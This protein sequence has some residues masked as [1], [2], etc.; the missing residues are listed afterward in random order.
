[1]NRDSAP[2]DLSEQEYS[3]ALNANF[4]SEHGTGQVNLQNEPSNIYCSGFKE[5]YKVIGHKYHLNQDRT[6]FFLTN[7]T[8]GFSEIGYINS[9]Y[10][11]DGLEQVEKECGC[12]I[13]VI[14][15]TP[16]EDQVQ[17]AT[18]TYNTLISDECELPS[19]TKCLNFSIDHPI[20]ES[21]IQIKDEASGTNMYFTDNYNPQRYLQLDYLDQYYLD[22]TACGDP[23]TVCLQ[24]DKLRVYP[25][26]EPFCITVDTIE[27]GGSL[28]AGNIEVIGAYSSSSGTELSE[29]FSLTNRVPIYDENNNI[30]DQTNLNYRTNQAVRVSVSG[31]DDKFQYYKLVVIYRSGLDGAVNYF[32]YG[33]YPTTTT[34]V[35][36]TDLTDLNKLSLQ[37]INTVKPIY[38]KA[39]G[40][41]Q[42]NGYLFQFGLTAKREINLQKVVSLM[43]AH[44]KWQTVKADEDLYKRGDAVSNYIGYMRDEVEP[45]SIRFLSDG[46]Y[47]SPNFF[48]IPRP[49]KVFELDVLG[50]D[51]EETVNETSILEFSPDCSANNRNRRWQFENTASV[52]GE[53][54]VPATGSEEI[55]VDRTEQKSCIIEDEGGAPLVVDALGDS[56]PYTFNGYLPYD[57]VTYINQNSELII[58]QN[59]P[60]WA[61][62]I[63]I[64]GN[65]E[66]YDFDCTPE[67]ADNCGEPTQIKEEIIALS[68]GSVTEIEQDI[69]PS[70]LQRPD[71]PGTCNQFEDPLVEDTTFK[72]DYLLP[73]DTVY[74]RNTPL[75][76]TQCQTA[77]SLLQYISSTGNT[78]QI[79]STFYHQYEGALNNISPL[80]TTKDS[81][82]V[83]P[84]AQFTGKVHT[85]ALW[86]KVD[87]A[88]RDKLTIELSNVLTLNTD[89]VCQDQLRLTFFAN[90]T[91]T[92][93]IATYSRIIDDMT[94]ANDSEK[95]LTLDS[96]DFPTGTAYIAIDTPIKT[97]IEFDLTVSGTSG[98]GSITISGDVYTLLFDTNPTVTVSN[99]ISTYQS[100]FQTLK[101][102]SVVGDG[103]TLSFRM[104][105][106]DYETYTFNNV[107]GD[108]DATEGD[109]VGLYHLTTLCGCPNLYFR[110][111]QTRIVT[112]VT[113]LLFGKRDTYEATCQYT[114]TVFNGCDPI[115]HE[116]GLFS[117]WESTLKY[118]CNPQ[119]FDS[120][121]LVINQ[122]DIPA[123]FRDEFEEYYV[124]SINNGTYQLSTEAD[125]QDKNIR[126]YKFPCSTTVPFMSTSE[127]GLGVFEDSLIYPIGFK[128][129]NEI[130]NAF[131][132]IALNNGLLT[133]KERLSINK[134]EIF[135]GD[136]ATDRSIIAKGL[137]FDNYKYQENGQDVYY[138]NYP[139]NSLGTD[140]FN[141]NVP[142]PF[143][144][145]SNNSFTFHSPDV[146]FGKP[147]L[148][149]ELK[150]E[151][152][153]FGHS[154]AEFDQV[155][156]HPT[157]TILGSDGYALATSL[158]IAESAFDVAT[159]TGDWLVLANTGGVSTPAAVIAFG[160]SIAAYLLTQ[161]F[162]TGEYRY[163]W[164]NTIR[165]LGNPEQYAYYGATVGKYNTF[166]Q[167][168]VADSKY[169]GIPVT[170][171]LK[172]GRWEVANEH[173]N[174]KYNVNN[175]DRE[176]VVFLH[177]G[178]NNIN[179]PAEYSDY[180]N[181]DTNFAL[182]SRARYGGTGRQELVENNAA[183][184][185]VSMKQYLPS[186]YGDIY[187][188]RWIHTG[189]CGDLSTQNECV[190]VFGGDTIVSRFSLKRKLPFFTTTAI[191]L[192]P[193]TP[194]R[195]SDYFNINPEENTNRYFLNY[196]TTQDSQG[197]GSIVFP[198]PKSEY[199]NMDYLEGA[200]SLYVKPPSKFYLYYYGIPYF[201]T[202][203]VYNCN[204][205]YAKRELHENFWPNV[206]DKI[207]WTQERNVSIREPEN[208][209]INPVYFQKPTK[210]AHRTLPVT[211]DREFYDKLV[212]Q[213][214]S[215]I[216]SQQDNNEVG[217]EDPWLQYKPLDTFTF[218]K[219]YGTLVDMD[220]IE[221]E[222][223]LAR[224][225]N[226]LAIFGAI[227]Q[228]RDRITPDTK[229]LGQGGIFAGRTLSFNK[230]DLGYA[231]TQHVQKVSCEF[232]HFWP[233]VKRGR[234]FHLLPNAK[235]LSDITVGVEKWFKENLPFKITSYV[236]GL[237]QEDLDNNYKGLG[238]SMGWD[239]RLKRLFLTKMDYRPLKETF[240]SDDIGFYVEEPGDCPEGYT[241]NPE[242]QSCERAVVVEKT[243]NTTPIEVEEAGDA[244]HGFNYP[245]LYSVYNSDGTANVDGG[246][247]TGYTY[248]LIEEDWWVGFGVIADRYLNE[249]AK[250]SPSFLDD[251]WYGGSAILE[252]S[253]TK[254]YYVALAGD[255]SFRFSVNGVV[256]MESDPFAMDPQH[257][258]T[259]GTSA[260]VKLH[261][262][263]IELEAGCN[264]ITI[265]GLN[266]GSAGLFAGAIIDNT[267]AELISATS[268]DQLNI[269]F[270]T[271]D[272]TELFQ[273][274]F[275][276]E[277]PD[278]FTEQ[279]PSACDLCDGFES[280]PSPYRTVE[281]TDPE[282]FEDCSF[283]IGYSPLLQ[284]WISYYSFK[285]NYYVAYNNYF[286]TG[287][288][289]AADD[290]EVG[291]WSHYPFKSSY[292]VFYGKR[293]PF[294][295]EMPLITNINDST[296]HSVNYL[297]D[298]RKY[299]DRY[300]FGDVFGKG[301]T[302]AYIYN[303]Q[304]NSGEMLLVPQVKNNRRQKIE[305]PKHNATN[306][307]IL[308]TE[309][310]GRW[311]FNT[312]YNRIRNE[313]SGLPI[314][315]NDCNQIDKWLDNR[316][317]D[318]ST[319]RKD[320]LRGDNYLL[321]LVQDQESR[322]H[323]IFRLEIDKRNIDA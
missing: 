317:L 120:S 287:I 104:S 32:E 131:L 93:D 276:F 225:T 205:R 176:N 245:A 112:Q 3:F 172:D 269:I 190:P 281:L 291:L 213:E 134:Y 246:S 127:D 244:S 124:D 302:K 226:G 117:H 81:S 61:D 234:V 82:A 219:S 125:F 122:T 314:W 316:L 142:H 153:Q 266:F 277:C 94:L 75:T 52:L 199:E 67:F 54:V 322:Y 31:L 310:N 271:E 233:D 202:E 158:A 49:P 57:L 198:T 64:I 257:G 88:G 4:Q 196:L 311:R 35:S 260:F 17:I 240:Y 165:N 108:L 265:E 148:P 62:V 223:I 50:E 28:P 294:T 22:S 160:V 278:G 79:D 320:R 84:N 41:A 113:D 220:S 51:F 55:L 175:V 18:C 100:A 211:Y 36:I 15:E 73:N 307:E 248:Q 208:F 187:D 178:D 215:V 207:K 183:S 97:N 140:N 33:V 143:S 8:T 146:H 168:Q 203:S 319:R 247:P 182:S 44:V 209:F 309:K 65:P 71:S 53:C 189:Y 21:N 227:D 132:D 177:L 279:G 109:P 171:Y 138:S 295:I 256:I 290:T 243:Q 304:N 58:A 308:Q 300:D 292:Q 46:G 137:L 249:L 139:L 224:F 144:S 87:F 27:F 38:E 170:T 206:G 107:S 147:T 306:T 30:L 105:E 59:F 180:D 282:Y 263:P 197:F 151:G 69:D 63:N 193:L 242:T 99:F 152:Y 272:A 230:T 20:H 221:S 90:C 92:S 161:T 111:S 181:L 273:S 56:T 289:Y 312:F 296:L 116:Y 274:G 23:V 34:K 157:Y 115:P 86:Y 48:F 9:F 288:N 16:L 129:D 186:Q 103:D 222:Q 299:Y 89:D 191:G 96:S 76:N 39:K 212:N 188:V 123:D 174:Q 159:Q 214:N 259:S 72:D 184:P 232:G 218:E 262:Y 5:G 228:L 236:D 60:V 162:K 7:P 42:G 12:D 91:D 217:I 98:E 19:G 80:Q 74:N 195:Y 298:V 231:G 285:P 37:D 267:E 251:T 253:E 216:Y 268:K 114:K 78:S 121:D 204:F 150:V 135:R 126:H 264:I 133:A 14:L 24:C 45:L 250:W 40:M 25:E 258:R 149:N 164:I 154:R 10:N 210:Y 235:G 270:S 297:M 102:I 323:Y 156:G 301:F 141:G 318:Y 163:E 252:V 315:K 305:Y 26:Y 43:G 2:F 83:D 313:E 280:V 283:T 194:F 200:N 261:I 293:Y 145:E 179:Y 130:I 119:L 284:S 229:N 238:I 101:N 185:Y 201:L 6:Y 128:I 255:N 155:E 66:N 13:K 173:N 166:L 237:T 239:E 68:V 169:R 29:Y 11:Y 303:Q 275:S 47:K 70:E 110:E 321:R 85:N 241:Y 106:E 1:M 118:P 77:D 192:A 286:Q 136:R 167:N 95:Y 254:T